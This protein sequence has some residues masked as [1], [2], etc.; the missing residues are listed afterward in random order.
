MSLESL[1]ARGRIEQVA[2][3][4]EAAEADLEQASKHLES[5]ALLVA[6]D[7]VMAYAALYDAARKA[8][9][10]HMRARGYR[11]KGLSG[12]HAKTFEYAA[13]VLA[14]RLSADELERLDDMRSVRNDSEYRARHV[15]SAEVHFD[16]ET[17]RAVVAAVT[18]DL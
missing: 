5:A 13:V 11:I 17:A 14:H 16:L 7:P 3:D 2:A 15:G 12:Y 1:V 6:S 8:V 9:S 4:R 18:A 10:A